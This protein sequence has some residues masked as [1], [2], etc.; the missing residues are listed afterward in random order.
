VLYFNRLLGYALILSRFAA[1]LITLLEPLCSHLQ[2]NPPSKV[3][4]VV[5][6]S[7]IVLGLI[8]PFSLDNI[9]GIHLNSLKH[10]IL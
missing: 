8:L 1:L 10:D 2:S 3:H 4:P 6:P 7:W 9:V 5:L